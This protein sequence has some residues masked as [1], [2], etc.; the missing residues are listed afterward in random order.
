M[1]TKKN[2]LFSAALSVLGFN[3]CVNSENDPITTDEI[4]TSE[5]QKELELPLDSLQTKNEPTVS[6]PNTEIKTPADSV[7]TTKEEPVPFPKPEVKNEDS[8]S[9]ESPTQVD[10]PNEWKLL[11][12]I[13]SVDRRNVNNYI[14]AEGANFWDGK[15][16]DIVTKLI[17]SNEI[18]KLSLVDKL[19]NKNN[20]NEFD[21]KK[22]YSTTEEAIFLEEYIRL[23]CIAESL[24]EEFK[25]SNDSKEITKNYFIYLSKRLSLKRHQYN[26][27]SLKMEDK[28]V[29]MELFSKN[30]EKNKDLYFF[31][32]SENNI[33]KSHVKAIESIHLY[34]KKCKIIKN[35]NKATVQDFLDTLL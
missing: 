33:E 2:I 23:L 29:E 16:V 7:K 27:V 17:N 15:M 28:S 34:K 31:L 18:P 3:A 19:L 25:S 22:I 10:Y 11:K 26:K 13:V 32:S 24:V 4:T 8:N 35:L 12:N 1:L 20:E 9:N 30:I 14:E 21:L 5:S 6:I